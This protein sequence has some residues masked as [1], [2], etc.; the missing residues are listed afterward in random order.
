MQACGTAWPYIEFDH[1]VHPRAV[2]RVPNVAA[3]VWPPSNGYTVF[4]WL[5][6]ARMGT[7]TTPYRLL[8]VGDEE[9]KVTVSLSLE[10]VQQRGEGRQ[11]LYKS[12]GTLV[13]RTS[14][15]H[16]PVIFNHFTPV[17]NHWYHI[18]VS[19]TRSRIGASTSSLVVDGTPVQKE[20]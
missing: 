4:L 12:Q 10:Q 2:L 15:E 11:F 6:I 13:L 20:K 16:K 7:E 9:G 1:C 14:G 18:A 8:R 17:A 5:Y 19:H 3:K